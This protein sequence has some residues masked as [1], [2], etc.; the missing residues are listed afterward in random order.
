M[1]AATSQ[2]AA[3]QQAR[4][5]NRAPAVTPRKVATPLPPLKLSQ[6][7]KIWPSIAAKR[8]EDLASRRQEYA[9]R[10]APP[11]RPWRHRTA[12][13][14]AAAHFL[15]VRSTLVAPILPEPILRTS[16]APDSEGE[17]QAERNGAQK[18]AQG[19]RFK[20]KGRGNGADHRRDDRELSPAN[21]SAGKPARRAREKTHSPPTKVIWARPWNLRPSKAVLRARECSLSRVHD[22]GFVRVQQH[23]VGGRALGQRAGGQARRCAPGSRSALPAH[24]SRPAWP[25]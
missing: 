8:R 1:S 10:S 18:I 19:Q 14:A 15:P 17:E 24:A 21:L 25:S 5:A 22:K 20:H 11:P 2:V 7:G 12:S 23:Q 9:A 16:P 6:T 4:P 13:V 3:D